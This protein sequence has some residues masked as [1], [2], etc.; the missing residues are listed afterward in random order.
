MTMKPNEHIKA[1]EGM[2]EQRDVEISC[3]INMWMIDFS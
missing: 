2:R 3:K 1:N